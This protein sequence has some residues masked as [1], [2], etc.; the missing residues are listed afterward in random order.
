M[1]DEKNMK[2]P[3]PINVPIE[4]AIEIKVDELSED[5]IYIVFV[6]NDDEHFESGFLNYMV[7]VTFYDNKLTTLIEIDWENQGWSLPIN[8]DLHIELFLKL[9][10]AKR[11]DGPDSINVTFRTEYGGSFHDNPCL[12]IMILHRKENYE[13]LDQVFYFSEK[14]LK[15]IDSKFETYYSSINELTHKFSES[16]FDFSDIKNNK[17]LERF[18]ST[19]T[20]TEKGIILEEII[21]VL[22]MKI[23]GF[24]IFE[25]YRT[26]TE[27]IDLVIYNKSEIPPWKNESPIILVECKN[28]EK[29]KVGKNEYVSFKAKLKN[30]SNRAKIGFIISTS[31]FTKDFE[32]ELLRDSNDDH[33]IIPIKTLEI[34]DL[35]IENKKTFS[36]FIL[37]PYTF[38]F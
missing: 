34:L 21:L 2:I 33:L 36:D 19:K 28:W 5:Y 10:L 27:E 6:A 35:I 29:N 3:E 31:G 17:L 32:R 24:K 18:Y 14:L 8:F 15:W 16:L 25:R 9:V 12:D 22:F 37:K 13:T 38:S 7:C 1:V 26:S 4:E 11:N 30:R 23:E 20:S